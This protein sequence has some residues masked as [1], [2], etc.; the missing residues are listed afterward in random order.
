M[1]KI[2]TVIII[3]IAVVGTRR[4]A[5]QLLLYPLASLMYISLIFQKAYD[6]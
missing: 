6:R 2:A 5:Y 1:M 4:G 3:V